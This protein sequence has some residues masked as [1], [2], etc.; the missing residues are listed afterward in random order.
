MKNSL[1]GASTFRCRPV[2]G[3]GQWLGVLVIIIMILL[4]FHLRGTAKKNSTKKQKC[5][6]AKANVDCSLYFPLL[7]ISEDGIVGVLEDGMGGPAD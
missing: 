3:N 7:S 6:S 5:A 4:L 2:V 1:P